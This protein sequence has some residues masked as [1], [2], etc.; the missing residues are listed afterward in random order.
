MNIA[1]VMNNFVEPGS[2][3]IVGATRKSGDFSMNILEHILSYG[4]AGKLYPINPNAGEILG[5]KAYADISGIVDPIDLALIVTAR[6]VVPVVLRSCADK[7]IKSAIIVAQGFSDAMDEEGHELSRQLTEIVRTTGIRVLGPN[8]FGTANAFINFSTSFARI[9][10]DKNPVGIVCQSG[11]FFHGLPEFRLTGKCI[12]LG[13]ACDIGFTEALDY[14]ENDPQVNVIGLHIEGV[15]N[16]QVLLKT[17]ERVTVKKPVIVLKTGRSEQAARAMQ[18]HTGSLAGNSL[19]WDSAL[20]RAGAIRVS[21]IEEFFDTVRMFSMAPLMKN[22]KIVVATFSGA[23][24]ILAMDAMRD[25]GLEIGNWSEDTTAKLVK[26]AP[27]WLKVGNP[28]DYW[29]IMMGYPDQGRAMS[30]VMEILLSDDE[31]GGVMFTQVAFTPKFDEMMAMFLNFLAEK[32]PHKPFMSAISGTYNGDFINGLQQDGKHL[33]FHTP[34][35]AAR[36]FSHLWHYSRLR[37][38]L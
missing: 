17:M 19:L 29:P 7:G 22:N 10:L 28:V 1:E 21:D 16:P 12:D 3:A 27:A 14:F 2:V 33:A 38:R 15:N 37:R 13:N 25:T 30:E 24:G 23:A 11:L 26:L 31:I 34:E 36:A 9:K 8:T 32:Y 18:S 4:Y 5:V 6:D 35:R 20:K